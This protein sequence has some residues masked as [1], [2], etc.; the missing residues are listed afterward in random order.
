MIS[1]NPIRKLLRKR[2]RAGTAKRLAERARKN[3]S[4]N[5]LTREEKEEAILF[6]RNAAGRTINTVY[7]NYLKDKSG[8]FYKEYIPEDL[9]YS[10]IDPYFNNT[11]EARFLDNKCYYDFL[12]AGLAMPKTYLK[13]MNGIWFDAEGRP[14][15]PEETEALLRG[16][17]PMFIKAATNSYGGKGVYY[18]PGDDDAERSRL[19]REAVDKIKVDIVVQEA[20]RQHPALARVNES[21]VNTIRALS[22]LRPD[23][24]VKIYSIILRMGIAGA[25]VDNASSGGITCGAGFDGRCTEAGY[26]SYVNSG[27]R[28]TE[29]PTSGLPFKDIVIPE[30][31][32]IIAFVSKAAL[33][34]PHFRLVSWDIA[35]REDGEPVLIE[36]NFF[37]GEI[38]FH[39]LNNGPLFG[40][41]TEAIL[42]EVY[43][44][45]KQE[46]AGR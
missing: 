29:H 28:L 45:G 11:K 21:S 44:G 1:L 6:Y 5:V 25:K 8:A 24:S 15:G 36:A 37:D 3:S 9:Y 42:R 14:A 41:D 20:L 16:G 34:I 22:L 19:F 13:R 23:G 26:Y 2:S 7:H 32:K 10:D 33:K 18:I 39:Q 30:M 12:F 4:G 43:A 31:D 40:E 17:A 27:K 46:K 38:D 35:L